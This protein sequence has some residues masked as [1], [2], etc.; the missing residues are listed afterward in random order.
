MPFTNAYAMSAAA[1]MFGL[2]GT[3]HET[4]RELQAT[5]LAVTDTVGVLA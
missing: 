2:T 4:N 3:E 1:A 5:V